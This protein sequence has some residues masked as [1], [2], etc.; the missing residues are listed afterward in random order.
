MDQ[1]HDKSRNTGRW[2]DFADA[3]GIDSKYRDDQALADKELA[4]ATAGP[5]DSDRIAPDDTAMKNPH[6]ELQCPS[7][8]AVNPA[9]TRHEEKIDGAIRYDDVEEQ[10]DPTVQSA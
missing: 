4:E 8:M 7:A 9:S 5:R 10:T 1:R 2:Q 6:G 3:T